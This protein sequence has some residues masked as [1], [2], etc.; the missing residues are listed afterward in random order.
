ME[1]SDRVRSRTSCLGSALISCPIQRGKHDIADEITFES[2]PGYVF[3]DS[4][5]IECGSTDETKTL[6][7][8]ITEH[9]NKGDFED[10]LHVIW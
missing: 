8:F 9:A 3:H 2:N 1:A 10:R 5:G 4:R 7:S 6:D